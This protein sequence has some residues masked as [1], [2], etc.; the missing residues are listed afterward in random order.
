M[1]FFASQSKVDRALDAF[2]H[3][4]WRAARRLLEQASPHQRRAAGDYHLGL[5]YWRG[6]GGKPDAAA[7]VECFARA[8]EQGHA[9]AQTAHGVALQSGVGVAKNPEAA[10]AC[11]RSAAGAGDCD[12]M[13][14]LAAL[15]E[16][17]ETKRLLFRAAEH[18]HPG[19]MR[20]L[21]DMTM[22]D[23]PVEALSWLY[24]DVALSGDE[25]ALRRAAALA[26]EMRADE[27]SAAQKVGRAVAKKIAR[28]VKGQE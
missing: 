21:A 16:P 23:D 15:S 22:R 24:A 9:A 11:F 12:A 26:L 7:A 18:G 27:I 25:A 20:Q 28:R 13:V 5:L 1:L 17:D 14:H 6:L 8:A 2:S 4:S 19:A 3:R 10:L